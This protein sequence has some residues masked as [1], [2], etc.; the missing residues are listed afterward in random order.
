MLPALRSEPEVRVI[1]D[2]N[3]AVSGLL[4]H[5][6]PREVLDAARAGH[7]RLCTSEELLAELLDVL[8]RP[9]F[10]QRLDLAGVAAQ[11]LVDGYAALAELV[12]P[13]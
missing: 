6:A 7:I 1:A 11:E 10:A 4:W 5:G 2:T 8:Q 13:A 3:T 9:K 12:A